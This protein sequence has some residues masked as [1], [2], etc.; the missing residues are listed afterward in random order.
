MSVCSSYYLPVDTSVPMKCDTS[1]FSLM[2]SWYA[3]SC[4]VI[5]SLVS[6]VLL[7]RAM[8]SL[9]L[10]AVPQKCGMWPLP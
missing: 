7:C 4:A 10:E 6:S 1:V 5:R 8:H 3:I 9:T 2:F